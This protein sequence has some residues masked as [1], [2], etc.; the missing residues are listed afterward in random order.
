MVLQ[1]S[2]FPAVRK[3]D[4]VPGEYYTIQNG[5]SVDSLCYPRGLFPESV[6]DHPENAQLKE[7][8]K[9][10][11]VL[12]AEDVLFLPELI[13][14][15][16]DA[17][18]DQRHRYR[19][20]AVPAQVGFKLLDEAGEPRA[21]VEYILRI[22]D[23]NFTG[24]TASDGSLEFDVP[25]DARSAKIEIPETGEVFDLGIGHMDPI[26]TDSGAALRLSNLGFAVES[27]EGEPDPD[28]LA[29]AVRRFQTKNDLEVTGEL[30]DATKSKLQEVAGY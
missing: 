10:M 7:L 6:W 22:D 13:Q 11:S 27:A 18:T 2:Q 24:K 26:D 14:K 17:A 8:R 1:R 3:E 19:R 12:L 15:Q 28:S 21:G 30:D 5:D 29:A 23:S 16:E 20:K 25:P 4:I 9:D